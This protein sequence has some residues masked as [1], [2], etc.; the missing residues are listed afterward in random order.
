MAAMA[1]RMP[2]PPCRSKPLRCACIV[3]NEWGGQQVVEV[4][5]LGYPADKAR[6]KQRKPLG[7][8]AMRER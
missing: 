5:P 8:I 1:N 6:P 7:E 4:M 3:W 2:A